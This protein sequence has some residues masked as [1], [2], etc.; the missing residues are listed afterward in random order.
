MGGDA[1]LRKPVSGTYAGSCV[2]QKPSFVVASVSILGR[3]QGTVEAVESPVLP[4]KTARLDAAKLHALRL[5]PCAVA[6]RVWIGFWTPNTV[7]RATNLARKSR[8]AK[9][10]FVSAAKG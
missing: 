4:A 9:V 8:S 5:R 3:M 7:V 2:R 1:S 6:G 10:G